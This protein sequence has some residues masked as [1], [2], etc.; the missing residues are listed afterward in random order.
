MNLKAF[1]VLLLCLIFTSTNGFAGDVAI[2]DIDGPGAVMINE[3]F[4]VTATI[5]NN[6]NVTETVDMRFVLPDGIS[7]YWLTPPSELLPGEEVILSGGF[8]ATECG[9]VTITAEVELLGCADTDEENNSRTLT[10]D[11]D[12]EHDISIMSF[13]VPSE[14]IRGRTHSIQVTL[15]NEGDFTE[16]VELQAFAKLSKPDPTSIIGYQT[17]VFLRPDIT[18]DGPLFIAPGDIQH[19]TFEVIVSLLEVEVE[20]VL[21]EFQV[22]QNFHVPSDNPLNNHRQAIVPVIDEVRLEKIP[23][24]VTPKKPIRES[25]ISPQ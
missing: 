17:L 6:G 2:I 13:V 16:E 1:F 12:G 7:G 11:V 24:I 5:A 14:F 4:T 15:R 21:L 18:P 23:R 20:T 3:R 8:R 9:P 19:Y 22:N 25:D 10:I